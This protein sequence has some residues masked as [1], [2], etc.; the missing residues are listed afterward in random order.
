M[1]LATNKKPNNSTPSSNKTFTPNTIN[2]VWFYNGPVYTIWVRCSSDGYAN[3]PHHCWPMI[4][5]TCST[6][7]PVSC[8]TETN[9]PRII[10]PSISTRKIHS[11][12]DIPPP[13]QYKAMSVL[14]LLLPH[15][16]RNTLRA[17][18]QFLKC[19]IANQQCNK[20][21][22]HNVATIIAPSLFSPR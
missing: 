22:K 12:A 16:N 5:C 21:S 4:L 14:C 13:D 17:F 6:K 3:Y 20:M 10:T 15:E 1:L 2:R 8:C 18:L 7:Q 19:V 9:H 11:F